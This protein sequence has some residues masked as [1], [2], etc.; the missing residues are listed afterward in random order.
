MLNVMKGTQS[1]KPRLWETLQENPNIFIANKYIKRKKRVKE[2]P[3]DEKK[4][5]TYQ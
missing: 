5:E 3:I 4:L 2:E 1:T